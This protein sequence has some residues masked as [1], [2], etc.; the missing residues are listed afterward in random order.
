[1]KKR[2]LT[3][4]L[5]GIVFLTAGCMGKKNEKAADKQNEITN[6]D[7]NG[8]PQ[9]VD[10]NTVTFRQIAESV[11]NDLNK[12]ITENNISTAEEVMRAYSPEAE[13]TEGRY[14]YEI[15]VNRIDKTL[16]EVTLVE[17][18]IM[19]DSVKGKKVLM[20]I[21]TDAGIL[22]VESIKQTIKCWQGRGHEHWSTE[23]CS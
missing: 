2:L 22:I 10:S 3:I 15:T 1:M 6:T 17:D 13:E 16:E 12:T 8:D 21:K 14:S 23:P 5:F 20:Q 11:I 4:S 18:G 19:D 9:E 7:I